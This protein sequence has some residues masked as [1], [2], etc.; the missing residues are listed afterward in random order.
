MQLPSQ[1]PTTTPP[2]FV[3]C[4]DGYTFERFIHGCN[5][6]Y[7]R[8]TA[9]REPVGVFSAPGAKDRVRTYQIRFKAEAEALLTDET[10]TKADVLQFVEMYIPKDDAST[11]A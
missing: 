9:Y 7:N 4:N 10:L 3:L 6:A 5:G 8:G 1:A 11:R 2:S